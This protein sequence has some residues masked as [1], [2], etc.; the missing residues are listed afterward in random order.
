M[1]IEIVIELIY[2]L[3][4]EICAWLM[5]VVIQHNFLFAKWASNWEQVHSTLGKNGYTMQFQQII[6]AYEGDIRDH[7]PKIFARIYINQAPNT[8]GIHRRQEKHGSWGSHGQFIGDFNL[9][10]ISFPPIY[11]LSMRIYCI[12]I[13]PKYCKQLF[14]PG[15]LSGC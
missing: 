7:G 14:L 2:V 15:I 13:A 6:V 9:L 4:S 11:Y 5:M 1:K 3:H 10:C 8:K 12:D